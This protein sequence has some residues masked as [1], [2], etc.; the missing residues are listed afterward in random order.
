MHNAALQPYGCAQINERHVYMPCL[1]KHAFQYP[2][3]RKKRS[4]VTPSVHDRLRSTDYEDPKNP[5]HF[6][7]R[8]YDMQHKFMHVHIHVTCTV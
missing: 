6:N 7:A 2:S 5:A 4:D 1:I 3:C 8:Q